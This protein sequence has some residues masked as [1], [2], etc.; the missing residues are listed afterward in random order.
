MCRIM[1]SRQQECICA[2]ILLRATPSSSTGRE[3]FQDCSGGNSRP[4]RPFGRG[5]RYLLLMTAPPS[6]SRRFNWPLAFT[7]LGLT[8]IAA[9]IFVF[10]RCA[11][12]P[13][14]ATRETVDQMERVGRDLRDAIVQITRLQPRVTINNRVYFEQTSPIAELALISR[15]LEVEHEFLH[16]WAGSTKRLRL[17]GTYTAKAG[18]DL[19][20]EFTVTISPEATI[21]RLPHA[22]LLGLEQNAV[23]LL[24]YENGFWNPISGADVQSELGALRKLARDRATEQNLAGKAEESFRSQLKSRIGNAPLLHVVFYDAT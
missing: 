23:E 19:R 7:V 9:G 22:Q 12:L 2:K 11:A 5:G 6:F 24:A 16:T 20:Q 17:H 10:N 4:S 1:A 14:R 3:V 15:K 13:G 21:V 18:F 8:A